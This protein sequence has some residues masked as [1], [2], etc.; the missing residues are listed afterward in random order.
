[1]TRLR[2]GCP[3]DAEQTHHSLIQFL[4]EEAG[5]VIDA[6]ET[7]DDE[8]LVEELG[9]LL[10]QV[11]F[12]AEIAR[13]EQRFDLDDVARRVTDKLVRRHPYVFSG[14]DVPEDMMASWE[15][16]KRAE[17]GRASALEGIAEHLSALARATKV[18]SRTRHHQVALSMAEEPITSEELGEQIIRLVQRAQLSGVDP[19]LATRAAVRE[20]E[21]RI[22]LAEAK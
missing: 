14:A 3:W 17:K 11:V 20:L 10:L 19:E 22:R 4:V 13:T 16:D 9:D 7:G 8:D 21:N 1:M 2:V 6:I 18:V 12:H 15:A 5:E